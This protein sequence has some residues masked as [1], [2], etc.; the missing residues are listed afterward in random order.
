M[1]KFNE[2]FPH[3]KGAMFDMDG[4]LLDSM[5]AWYRAPG[6]YLRSLGLKFPPEL[7]ETLAPMSAGEQA[8]YLLDAGFI[9]CSEEEISTGIY[10]EMQHFYSEEAREKPGAGQFLARLYEAGIPLFVLSATP[11]FLI[12]IGLEHT[13]LA[14]YFTQIWSAWDMHTSKR[15]PEFFLQAQRAMGVPASQIWLFED[16][17]Y[18]IKTAKSLGFRIAAI[19]EES[20]RMDR[21]EIQRMAD[22]WI[23]SYNSLL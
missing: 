7:L 22:I 15:Q 13:G 6:Q 18:S 11:E 17:L 20:A 1:L 4:T 10:R 12:R 23:T 14:R 21:E 9:G 3:I 2:M 5:W 8:K 19:Q 16:A